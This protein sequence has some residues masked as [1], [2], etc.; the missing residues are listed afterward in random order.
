PVV[1]F[2]LTVMLLTWQNTSTEAIDQGFAGGYRYMVILA[3]LPAIHV[4]FE[5]LDR[6]KNDPGFGARFFL[7]AVQ[8]SILA[9]AIIVRSSTAYALIGAAIAALIV[10]WR[11]WKDGAAKWRVV[12]IAACGAVVSALVLGSMV[13]SVPAEYVRTGRVFG[14]IWHRV[15]I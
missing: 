1:F 4:L 10:F 3:I 2:A 6:E 5:I 7:L 8:S 11:S 9:F 14:N 12:Q 13:A 15:F